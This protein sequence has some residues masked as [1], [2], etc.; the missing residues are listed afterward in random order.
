M[1]LSPAL[2]A[3]VDARILGARQAGQAPQPDYHVRGATPVAPPPQQPAQHPAI[4]QMNANIEAER[5][6]AGERLKARLEAAQQPIPYAVRMIPKVPVPDLAPQQLDQDIRPPEW[7]A[8]GLAGGGTALA[9]WLWSFLNGGQGY[10][11]RM[12]HDSVY[13]ELRRSAL[14]A[15]Y[16]S[17]LRR[18]A[19]LAQSGQQD[20]ARAAYREVER[21]RSLI[22]GID[23]GQ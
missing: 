4:T 23:A 13:R 8:E 14:V 11:E 6:A 10:E 20:H 18:A 19:A 17:E 9:N 12:Q 16:E 7:W 2:L 22:R 3:H 21:L 5:A 1:A 15:R